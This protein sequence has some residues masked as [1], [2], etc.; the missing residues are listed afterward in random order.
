MGGAR[1][2]SCYQYLMSTSD[3]QNHTSTVLPR[4]PFQ[5][6]SMGKLEMP[7]IVSRAAPC[8]GAPIGSANL[9]NYLCAIPYPRETVRQVPVITKL[10]T[11]SSQTRRVEEQT[12]TKRSTM[13]QNTKAAE[14]AASAKEPVE[15]TAIVKA[16]EQQAACVKVAEEQRSSAQAA[17]EAASAD[18]AQEQTASVKA[19]EEAAS[20][21]AVNEA[22]SAKAA[23]KL[24]GANALEEETVSAV[25]K[26]RKSEDF[27]M[28]TGVMP[29]TN[30]VET[31]GI[32]SECAIC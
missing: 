15:Q 5:P 9:H 19:V 13:Q 6:C 11:P 12:A 32:C 10:T 20:V 21:K 22:A 18:A 25:I 4:T 2:T 28:S 31:K 27:S 29:L 23:N 26:Y 8:L 17:E 3:Q 16:V 30:D 14:E 1:M 7:Q 24:V